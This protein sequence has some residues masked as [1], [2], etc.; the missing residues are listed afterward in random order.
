MRVGVVEDLLAGV[1][2]YVAD[3]VATTAQ[4][5]RE[6]G[7]EVL[8]TRIDFLRHAT[9]MHRIVQETEAAAVHAPWF[10]DQ[11]DRYADLVRRRLEAGR[12]VPASAYLDAQRARRLL[13]DEVATAMT[14][15]DALI[16]PATP[17]V[18]PPLDENPL[19]VAGETVDR[20]VA[21]LRCVLPL[22]QLG[23]PV[24]SVPIGAHEG[25]PFGLQVAGRPGAEAV[26]LAVARA[27]ERR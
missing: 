17:M 3:G 12:M 1:E 15:L 21:L 18:A 26:V 7:A 13:L 2:P 27:C 6:L 20:R 4:F 11:R 22:S 14:G 10:D 24:A 23:S 16:A 25:L 8:D 5:L 9:A 19:T